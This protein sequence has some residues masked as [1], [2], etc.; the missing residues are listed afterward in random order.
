MNSFLHDATMWLLAFFPH[1]NVKYNGNL[2]IFYGKWNQQSQ[3][4]DRAGSAVT[5]PFCKTEPG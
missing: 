1:N 4:S 5:D 2:Q 3:K